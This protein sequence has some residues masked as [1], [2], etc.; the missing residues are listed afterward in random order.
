MEFSIPDRMQ[1]V[2]AEVRE[3]LNRHIFPL[4]PRMI[5][6]PFSEIT[7]TLE[8][9][10]QLVRDMGYWAPQIPKEYGGMGLEFMHHALMSEEL[11]RTPLGH[12]TFGCQAPDA[13][14]MEILIEFGTPSQKEK[15]LKPV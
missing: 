2:L 4:E 12:Y 10:R 15:Y 14:N 9:K 1:K 7:P 13:G 8:E 6:E 11:G 5:A 3:F